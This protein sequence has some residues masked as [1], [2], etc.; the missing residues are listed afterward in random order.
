MILKKT[1][2]TLLSLTLVI[3]LSAGA[4]A[5]QWDEITDVSGHWA[6]ETIK[7]GF[8]DGLILG[9]DDGHIRPDAPITA[10]EM[11]TILTRVLDAD[12]K[13]SLEGYSVPVDAWY[14]EAAEKAAYLGLI[15]SSAGSLDAAMTR[16]AAFAMLSTAFS[17]TPAQPDLSVLSA[18]S[19]AGKLSMANKPAIAAMVSLGLVKG[20]G[21]SLNAN[22]SVSRAEFLTVLYRIASNYITQ[23][24]LSEGLTGGS[25]VNG[26]SPASAV[27]L[28]SGVWYGCRTTSVSIDGG[29]MSA[30]T[31]RCDNMPS[32]SFTSPTR[33]ELL[34][35]DCVNGD[36]Y[37]APSN[38]T[39][40]TLR[41]AGVGEAYVGAWAN[42]VELLPNW[43]N[44]VI[45]GSHNSLVVSGSSNRIT[46]PAGSSLGSLTIL[47]KNCHITID[48][49]VSSVTVSGTG[50]V[51][52]G[53]GSVSTLTLNVKDSQVSL[54]V[55]N[56]VENFPKV[57]Y[58]TASSTVT[59]GY[60]GNYTLAWAQEHD[61]TDE[62]KT[63]WVNGRGLESK[64]D[65]L[66]WVSIAMQRVNIFQGT[67]G[68]YELIRSN[69][70]GTG[71][72]GR[73][74]PVGTYTTTYKQ[75][76]GW[77]T[78]SYTVKPVVGFKQGTGY[79]FHSRLYYPNSSNIKDASIGYPISHGCV[80]MY[81]EDVNYIFDNIP[82]GTTVVVY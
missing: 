63:A 62:V 59:T 71:A 34:T 54:P 50:T 24:K 58:E 81:D 51:L 30:L 28:N 17:L 22:G 65:Y 52:D 25:V 47:G 13:L 73:G 16:Q 11:I 31:L 29:S 27:S 48:G 6:E 36:I 4:F 5:S 64:T 18:Y 69:I 37:A 21:G 70:V 61:Y 57:D 79:A 8:E 39:V 75:T 53:S 42:N 68:S 7:Q 41:L 3:G 33:V 40:G 35:V 76:N 60:K 2:C 1:L 67:Q 74:T 72:P 38:L 78:S 44:M 66:I 15:D 12:Q 55:S 14:Y 82:V 26:G 49:T 46:V 32:L 20:S 45:S 77:T 19:D 23:E 43:K 80:R 9:D 56:R 10:A